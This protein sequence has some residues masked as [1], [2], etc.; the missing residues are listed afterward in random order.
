[1]IMDIATN[2]RSMHADRR[3]IRKVVRR[4]LVIACSS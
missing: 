4:G 3:A 2:L 1:M